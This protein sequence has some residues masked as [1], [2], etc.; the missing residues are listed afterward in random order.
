MAA[1]AIAQKYGAIC[2]FMPKPLSDRTGNGTHLHISTGQDGRNTFQDDSDPNGVGL[3]KMAYHFMGGVFRHID[4]L[5]ALSCPSVNSYKRI[6]VRGSKS[7]ATW[8]PVFVCYGDNNRTALVRVPYGHLEL[9]SVDS[10]SNPYLL[11]AA[12]LGAGLDGI[13]NEMDPGDPVNL[14]LYDTTEEQR[15]SLGISNLP[16][17]LQEALEALKADEVIRNALGPNLAAEF[18][19][20]KTQE[21]IDYSRCVTDWEIERYLNFY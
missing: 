16:Q 8:A 15:R 12:V 21:W 2:S 10:S 20:L 13:R 6:V 5:T 4:A 18:I 3:S 1:H 17:S 9:R 7:G 19:K 11:T 14:N